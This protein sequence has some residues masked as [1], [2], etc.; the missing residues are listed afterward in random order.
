MPRLFV[1]ILLAML[2]G[3]D[4]RD[5]KFSD[6]YWCSLNEDTTE[7]FPARDYGDGRIVCYA[8]DSSIRVKEGK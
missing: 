1:G 2:A 7:R 8:A 3:C 6:T 4:L 5:Y